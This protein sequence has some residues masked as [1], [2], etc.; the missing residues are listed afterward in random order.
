MHSQFTLCIHLLQLWQLSMNINLSV[1]Q[2][3]CHVNR[4]VKCP[5]VDAEFL[6]VEIIRHFVNKI[7]WPQLIVDV[8]CAANKNNKKCYQNII[9]S[10]TEF[11]RDNLLRWQPS[12][13]WYTGESN[14]WKKTKNS[15]MQQKQTNKQLFGLCYNHC[16]SHSSEA[17]QLKHILCLY[18]T[19]MTHAENTVDQLL[20]L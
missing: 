11:W 3:L 17:W 6:F 20:L 7:Q 13:S 16:K 8:A 9:I 18:I 5:L 14:N 19:Y 1:L 2:I 12:L 4:Q 15:C 10:L